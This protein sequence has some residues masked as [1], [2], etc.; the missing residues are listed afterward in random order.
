MKPRRNRAPYLY[1]GEN[2]LIRTDDIVGIFDL[3]TSTLSMDT[4]RFLAARNGSSEAVSGG[5]PKGFVLTRGDRVYFTALGSETLA[6]RAKGN[7]QSAISNHR[8]AYGCP[9]PANDK[10]ANSNS[11]DLS[12][13]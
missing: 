5:L 13:K 2:T 12:A 11:K 3:D 7:Q 9:D 8:T 6:G 4:R 1:A 10:S